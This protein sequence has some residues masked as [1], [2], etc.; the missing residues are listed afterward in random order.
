MGGTDAGTDRRIRERYAKLIRSCAN[1]HSAC[2]VSGRCMQSGDDY[3]NY[4]TKSMFVLVLLHLNPLAPL[5]E[6]PPPPNQIEFVELSA[7][8]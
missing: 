2:K 8:T 5:W 3:R 6:Q 7:S 1:G 4:L